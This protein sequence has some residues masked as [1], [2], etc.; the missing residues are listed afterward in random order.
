[1][2]IATVTSSTLY[3][4]MTKWCLLDLCVNFENVLI[5]NK[6]TMS[7]KNEPLLWIIQW[8]FIVRMKVFDE[9]ETK[10]LVVVGNN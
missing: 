2:N 5:F 7:I 10:N 4:V 9:I 1:M 3:R 8:K 6:Q